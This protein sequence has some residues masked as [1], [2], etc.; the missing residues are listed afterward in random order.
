MTEPNPFNEEVLALNIPESTWDAAVQCLKSNSGVAVVDL[1]S[2]SP[3][4]ASA[5]EKIPRLA[6]FHTRQ[7][8][9]TI[10]Q[11]KSC[12]IPKEATAAHA[13]GYHA[14]GLTMEESCDSNSLSR[15]NHYREGIVFS[16]GNSVSFCS[17][18]EIEAACTRK[19]W[20][21][22]EAFMHSIADELLSAI[23]R[24]LH[25][26]C[27]WLQDNLGPTRQN[28]Q[29]HLKQY[30]EPTTELTTEIFSPREEKSCSK[31]DRS[32][33]N[34]NQEQQSAWLASHTDPSLISIIIH[35]RPGIQPGAMGLQYCRK[36][37][38]AD[39]KETTDEQGSTM[40]RAIEWVE[41]ECSGHCAAVVVVG[42]VLSYIT[43]NY[44]PASRHR[45]VRCPGEMSQS[46][47]STRMAAT[48]FVRPAGT[49]RLAVPPS[50]QDTFQL[51]RS[52]TFEEWN[53][54]VSRNYKVGKAIA[55]GGRLYKTITGREGEAE[56]KVT[57]GRNDDDSFV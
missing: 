9:P 45:V 24:D 34:I 49:A 41:V 17:D 19:A 55:R 3:V 56:E 32:N 8:L 54:R 52:M 37:R 26:P 2:S 43:G 36:H 11:D 30:V 50:L 33:D 6:F 31:V 22:L 48:L 53:A 20:N 13:T 28:S 42:S 40:N 29:W 21:R 46:S 27:E 25:L 12:H 14:A 39:T 35:D 47:S 10:R 23:E 18:N 4:S 15:Y 51:K 44:Y 5:I 7:S 1:A 16:D 57:R 38:P